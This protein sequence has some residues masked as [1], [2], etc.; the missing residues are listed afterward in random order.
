M[1]VLSLVMGLPLR[2]AATSVASIALGGIPGLW[3]KEGALLPEMLSLVV[4]A[5]VIGSS[6]GARLALRVKAPVIKYAVV[7]VM[8]IASIQL[9]QRGIARLWTG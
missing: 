1:P 9:L 2:V 7:G 8:A 6:M 3:I 4:P 5:A